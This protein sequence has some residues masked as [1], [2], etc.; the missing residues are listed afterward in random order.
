[1]FVRVVVLSVATFVAFVV[2]DPPASSYVY[3]GL[4]VHSPHWND[5]DGNRIEA[6]GKPPLHMT[7]LVPKPHIPTSRN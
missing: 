1:M 2:A 3:P 7:L 5:T 4:D 6:H